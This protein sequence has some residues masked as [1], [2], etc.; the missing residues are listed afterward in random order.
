MLTAAEG[1]GI[2]Q[3]AWEH[4][5]QLTGKPDCSHLVNE[6]YRLAGFPY[7]Y[8]SSF[9]LFARGSDNFARVKT[10]QPG[11]LIVWPGHVGLVVDPALHSFYSSVTAG[12]DTQD[13]DSKYWRQYGPSRFYRYRITDPENI[14]PTPETRPNV[15]L[16]V[17]EKVQIVT[18]PVIED[19]DEDATAPAP[20]ARAT[21]RSTSAPQ[22]VKNPS[23]NPARSAA[24]PARSTRA[25]KTEAPPTEAPKSILL[26]SRGKKPSAQEVSEAITE[27]SNSARA[28]LRPED[29]LQPRLPVVVFDQLRVE[30]VHVK[31]DRGWADVKVTSRASLC[32]EKR[33][34][35]RRQEKHRWELRRGASGWSALAPLD[36][37]YIPR[38]AAVR[39]LA[40][41]LSKLAASEKDS[42]ESAALL[43]Q[44]AQL[45]GFLN[46][47]LKN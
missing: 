19:E 5:Q 36:R 13:Y 26:V 38:D 34:A 37:I 41:Q 35:K 21:T 8:A 42:R 27:L 43:R 9:D 17:P 4:Q 33:E 14:H 39:V 15:A 45:A 24:I 44:E 20:P 40:V 25:T 32:S 46:D 30:N 28:A 31:G 3:A 10:P 18:V 23:S 1:R 7:A 22:P 11:D 16:N 2:V 6:I 12:L 29:L 47:L